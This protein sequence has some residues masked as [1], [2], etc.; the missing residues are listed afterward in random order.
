[1][2]SSPSMRKRSI[3]ETLW[4]ACLGLVAAAGCSAASLQ[5]DDHGGVC[6]SPAGCVG[7]DA[8]TTGASGW[9]PADESSDGSAGAP[10][11]GDEATSSEPPQGP[12]LP[13][14][15]A[16]ALSRACGECH[17]DTPAYGAPMSLVDFDDLHVPAPTDP[18]RAVFDLV[19]ERITADTKMMP[20]DDDIT[21]AERAALLSWIEAGAP[22]DP[23][24]QCGDLPP[25]DDGPEPSACSASPIP[26]KSPAS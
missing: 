11:G 8:G 21:D 24:A 9:D 16:A 18:T 7:D 3:V 5:G 10:T 25:P 14:D 20:P 12:Q 17:G 22:A 2:Q 4:C 26:L 23:D 1:M 13:C 19:G 15:V 6:R